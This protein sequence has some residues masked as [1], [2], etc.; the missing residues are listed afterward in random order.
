MPDLLQSLQNHDIGFLRIVAG[1][2]GVDL[3]SKDLDDATS[4]LAASLLDPDLALELVTSLNSEARSAVEALAAERRADALGGIC[5]ALRP[6]ARDGRRQTRSGKAASQPRIH[7][8][9]PLLSRPA[10]PS[11]LQY[12]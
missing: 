7:L 11:V 1:L 6:G 12:R 8:G 10:L 5:Q 9:S 2:W 4:E 3:E